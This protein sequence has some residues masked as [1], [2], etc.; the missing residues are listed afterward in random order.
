MHRRQYGVTIPS[1]CQKEP[2]KYNITDS[3]AESFE[4]GIENVQPFGLD[5]QFVIVYK[6]LS[7]FH[8]VFLF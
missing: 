3:N 2:D 8:G 7:Q 1:N 4:F 6:T 5:R